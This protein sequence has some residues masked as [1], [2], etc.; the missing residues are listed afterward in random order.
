[1][2]PGNVA[3]RQELRALVDR[4]SRD[5]ADIS[6]FLNENRKKNR[7]DPVDLETHLDAAEETIDAEDSRRSGRLTTG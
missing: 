2:P 1:M 4:G 3:S 7:V 6:K 5:A